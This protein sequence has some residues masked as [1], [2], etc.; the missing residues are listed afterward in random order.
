MC[1]VDAGEMFLNFM[2]HPTLRPHC[3]VDL[4]NCDLDFSQWDSVPSTTKRLLVV[5]W[6]RIA[7]GLKWSPYQA[8]KTLHFAEEVMKGDHKDQTNVFHWDHVRLNL[9]G[10]KDCD[11]KLPWVSKVKRSQ[12]GTHWD[13]AADL[14]TFVD[15]L[16]PIGGSKKEVWQ[17]GRRAL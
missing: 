6:N 15:D 7:M 4:T 17:A 1:D 3:G 2:M 8:V 9:P 11:P 14:I 13:L 5:T 12:D 16:R 10:D